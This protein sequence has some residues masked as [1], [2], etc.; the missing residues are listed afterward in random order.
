V[1]GADTIMD[2]IKEATQLMAEEDT[3]AVYLDVRLADGTRVR[4]E[5]R[6]VAAVLPQQS[7]APIKI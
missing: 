5:V 6:M 4:F 7:G 3:S 2:L 1:T